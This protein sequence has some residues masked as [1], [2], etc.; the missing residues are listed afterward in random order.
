M[1]FIDGD[2]RMLGSGPSVVDRHGNSIGRLCGKLVGDLLPM[3][4]ALDS[5]GRHWYRCRC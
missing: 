4:R 3:G 1:P 5:L 2:G